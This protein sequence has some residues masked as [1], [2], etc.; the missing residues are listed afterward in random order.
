MQEAS[1]NEMRGMHPSTTI[2]TSL[3]ETP[4]TFVKTVP[5]RD[6]N[7]QGSNQIEA[8]RRILRTREASQEDALASTRHFFVT[9]NERNQV[10]TSEPPEEVS[11]VAAE[12]D[13]VISPT[14]PITS[15]NTPITGIETGSP[16]TFFPMD[17][18][19]NTL[20]QQ[21]IDHTCGCNVFQ[22]VKQMILLQMIWALQKVVYVNLPFRRMDSTEFRL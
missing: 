9:V 22:M 11:T 19:L 4:S 2:V 1:E 16:R 20:Q 15:A 14:V 10:V 12:R 21:P 13:T 18:L 7:E 17:H 5:G 6:S 8:T 3:E